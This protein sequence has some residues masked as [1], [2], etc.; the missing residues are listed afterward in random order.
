MFAQKLTIFAVMKPFN[1][2]AMRKMIFGLVACVLALLPTAC[3]SGPEYE[4]QGDCVVYRYWTFS[5][6]WRNDTL[7]G[8][9]VATFAQVRNWLGHDNEHVYYKEKLVP[10]ADV[11]SL[12]PVRQPLFKDKNDYYY[13]A[14]PMH[15]KDV[16]SFKV[17]KWF[18]DDFWAQDA[19]CVYYDTVRIDDADLP[20]FKIL[21]MSTAKDN[22][23]VYYFGRVIP[24][25]DPA[26][27]EPIKNSVYNR[28]KSHIWC[29]DD[30]LKD[31]DYETFA[32]DD[33]SRAHDK[34]GTF[35]WEKRDTVPA[36]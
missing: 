11:A 13:Q 21:E 31:V 20:S 32:V 24:D 12:E 29:G 3:V 5:F 28:D 16:E 9:D 36:E 18:E 35:S 7:P 19:Q 6:G 10:G 23:H 27:F 34:Y 14:T 4:V 8:A 25:A 22:N 26:T 33:M 17:T 15:V 2:I 1:M 30:L